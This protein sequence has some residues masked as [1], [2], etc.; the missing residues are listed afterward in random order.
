MRDSCVI[1]AGQVGV[2]HSMRL[3]KASDADRAA[4]L[5]RGAAEG[6]GSSYR[7]VPCMRAA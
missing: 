2:Q 4:P 1:E 3:R 5:R 7:Y 6:Q